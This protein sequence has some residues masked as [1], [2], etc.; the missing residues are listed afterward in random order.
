MFEV[1]DHPPILLDKEAIRQKTEELRDRVIAE[2]KLTRDLS[3]LKS[4]QSLSP[5]QQQAFE[6]AYKATLRV[7]EGLANE[8]TKASSEL[9]VVLQTK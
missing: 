8:Y 4:L 2:S 9:I 5:T 1:N 6:D 3:Y 7:L